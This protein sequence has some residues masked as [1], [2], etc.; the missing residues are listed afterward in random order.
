M[1]GKRR[2]PWVARLTTGYD[3]Q[4]SQK[5]VM[6]GTYATKK[7]AQAALDAYLYV[8]ERPKE[9]T[10]KE[11]FEGW[12]A[13][14]SCSIGT[15]QAYESG[16]RKLKRFYNVNASEVD[17]DM[18][19]D[20][21]D[22]P[23]V[24]YSTAKVIK[25]VLS[26]CLDYAFAHDCCAASRVGLLK[27]IKMPKREQKAERQIFTDDEIQRCIDDRAFVAVI[28]LFT[29]LR[30][31][32]FL[33]LKFED[34]HLD[35]GWLHVSKSKTDAGIRDVPIPDRLIPFFQIYIDSGLIGMSRRQLEVHWW[36]EYN[37]LE[38]H[39]RHECRHT[40]ITKLTEAGIDQ[41]YIKM[42]VGHAGTITEDVYSHISMDKL[43]AIVNEVFGSLLPPKLDADGYPVYDRDQLFC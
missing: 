41:R 24:T 32:E 43:R 38:N 1:S 8:P 37:C 30:R 3:D 23:P 2:K 6:I 29:G 7:E 26:S 17:L 15:I 25:K 31:D 36:Q 18:L 22:T 14:T 20:A 21:V 12:K 9:M 13:Q 11:A 28:L 42:I 39:T 19:Q 4:G 5:K 40:Y 16:F 33:N 34:I 35:Q 27:Y 10:I